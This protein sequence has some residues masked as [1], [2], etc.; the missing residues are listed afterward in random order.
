MKKSVRR[1]VIKLCDE[2]L[3]KRG[4]PGGT[5]GPCPSGAGKPAAKPRKPKKTKPEPEPLPD[6]SKNKA[7]AAMPPGTVV[8]K[9]KSG[10]DVHQGIQ[11]R[12][13]IQLVP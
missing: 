2:I 12:I 4:G 3:E 8:K 10:R 7:L 13:R 6:A 1:A 5:P 11:E 9:S